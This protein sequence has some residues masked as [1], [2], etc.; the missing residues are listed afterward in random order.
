MI[1]DLLVELVRGQ[2]VFTGYFY[3]I[4]GNKR[5]EHTLPFAVTTVTAHAFCKVSFYFKRH[6]ATVTTTV[7]CF[8]GTTIAARQTLG[9]LG[10]RAH[11]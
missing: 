10:S 5:E 11:T 3:L 1:D 9:I 4:L 7:I 2:G 6:F 8:H